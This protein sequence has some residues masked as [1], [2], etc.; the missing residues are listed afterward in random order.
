LNRS[1]LK[2]SKLEPIVPVHIEPIN[3]NLGVI[4][5]NLALSITE[6]TLSDA[7]LKCLNSEP[8]SFRITSILRP[9]SGPIPS[10]FKQNR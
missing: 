9:L 4:L 5:G 8:Y 10:V 2:S 3:D 1:T 6:D 7:W